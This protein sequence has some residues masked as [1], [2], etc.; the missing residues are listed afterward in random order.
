MAVKAGEMELTA[1]EAAEMRAEIR[2]CIE[3]V[4]R[5]HQQMQKDDAKAEASAARRQALLNQLK[6]D[7]KTVFGESPFGGLSL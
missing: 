5:L 7:V 1:Q 6:A 3:E 2:R 4:E